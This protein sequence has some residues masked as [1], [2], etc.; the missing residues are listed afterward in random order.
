MD[1]VDQSNRSLRI[2][3]PKGDPLDALKLPSLSVCDAQPLHLAT[4]LEVPQ[5]I[6]AQAP[7][8]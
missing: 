4:Q 3:S 2:S 8:R 5:A 1:T 6:A 7:W